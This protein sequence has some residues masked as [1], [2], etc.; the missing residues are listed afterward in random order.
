MLDIFKNPKRYSKFF[1]GLVGAVLTWALSTYP[2]SALV[3]H[4][5]SLASALLTA[6]GVYQVSNEG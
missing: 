2:D 5:V 4:W 1:V 3:Q 6:A